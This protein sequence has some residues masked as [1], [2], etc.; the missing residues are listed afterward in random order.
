MDPSDP[1]RV[2]LLIDVYSIRCKS[3]NYLLELFFN[4]HLFRVCGSSSNTATTR[5][6]S[7]EL[8]VRSQAL[9]LDL[10]PNLLFSCALA[11]YRLELESNVNT[12]VAQSTLVDINCD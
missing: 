8:E 11:K 12:K 6:E 5:K 9:E 10:L 7:E 2:L 4:S 3:Y 1:L